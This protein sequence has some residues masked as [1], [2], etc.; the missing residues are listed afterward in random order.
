MTGFLLKKNFY[1]LWDNL[2]KIALVNIGFLLCVAVPVFLPALLVAVPIISIMVLLFGI[3]LCFSYLGVAAM[4]LTVISDH[5][6][7]GFR[8]FIANI[9]AH[10]SKGLILGVFVFAGYLLIAMVIPFYVTMQSLVG[11]LVA[12][13]VFWFMI[14]AILALQFY[15]TVRARLDDKTSLAIKKCFLFFFDNPLFAIFSL[16]HNIVVF[17]ISILLALVFPGP[18]G[19]LLYLDQALRLRLLKYDYLEKNP[20]ANKKDIPWDALLIDERERVGSRSLRS[21]IFPWKD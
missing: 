3:L 21:F 15:F 2:F 14:M 7:F 18:A 11:L 17:I 10:W 16:L 20:E 6:E 8:D 4:T 1:D 12:A 19:L 5:G 13:V 9:R